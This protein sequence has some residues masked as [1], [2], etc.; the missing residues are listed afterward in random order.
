MSG[1]EEPA[2]ADP[3][4]MVPA[5]LLA[6]WREWTG[7][8]DDELG[9]L[10]REVDGPVVLVTGTAARSAPGWDGRA[11]PVSGVVDPRGRVLLALPPEHVRWARGRVAE[12]AGLAELRAALPERLGRLGHAVYRAVYRWTTAPTPATVLPDVGEWRPVGDPAVPDWL[13]PF[14]GDAL[15]VLDASGAYLA[16]VGLKR[17]DRHVHEI[18]VGTDEAARGRG[19]ARRLVAQAARHLLAMGVVPTYLHDPRNI[20]SARVADA[21]GLPDLGW[22]ALGLTDQPVTETLP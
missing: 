17:H 14:G 19:L 8:T 13:R 15:V 5:A 11:H 7:A 21:A 18:A 22:G 9:V 3:T 10:G 16:G 2:S 1:A 6:H 4:G 20:A 12:G